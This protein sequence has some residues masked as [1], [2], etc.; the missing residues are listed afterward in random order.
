MQMGRRE[1]DGRVRG[2]GVPSKNGKAP[3]GVTQTT[4]H[5]Y[6][7]RRAGR[8]HRRRRPLPSL[9]SCG[10]SNIAR[11]GPSKEAQP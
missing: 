1:F 4:S 10:S 8:R 9:L 7:V 3:H 2:R 6:S 11:Q 5:C